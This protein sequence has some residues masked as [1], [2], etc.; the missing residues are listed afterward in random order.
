MELE[1]IDEEEDFNRDLLKKLLP[2]VST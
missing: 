2:Q 1:L